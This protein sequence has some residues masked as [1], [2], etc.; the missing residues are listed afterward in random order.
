[1]YPKTSSNFVR[2]TTITAAVLL[3][4]AACGKEE[5]KKRFEWVRAGNRLY[6]DAYGPADTIHDFRSLLVFADDKLLRI[7][8]EVPSGSNFYSLFFYDVT[9]RRYQVKR[10]G[11]YSQACGSCGGLIV[12]C[13]SS[14]DY[15]FAP[16]APFLYQALPYYSCSSEPE[17]TNYVVNTDTVVTVPLGTFSAYVLRHPNGDRSYWNPREGLIMYEARNQRAWRGTLRLNRIEH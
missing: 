3:T 6:Y 5:Y 9:R 17:G 13:G 8:E 10:G 12:S 14:F 4:C 11:L 15:L 1:M 7:Q 2:R 16:N